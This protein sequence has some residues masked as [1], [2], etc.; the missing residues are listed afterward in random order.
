MFGGSG[1]DSL[2][3]GLG[4]DLLSG[5][6]G[7]DRF[8]FESA[9]ESPTGR[10]DRIVDFDSEDPPFHEEEKSDVKVRASV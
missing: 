8:L 3:G 10:A 7:A 6:A 2:S 5:G 4:R 9:A 1:N